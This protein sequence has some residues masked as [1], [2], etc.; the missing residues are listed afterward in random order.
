M[1]DGEVSLERRV[2]VAEEAHLTHARTAVQ[3]DQRRIGDVLSADH[4]PL[5]DPAETYVLGLR[6]AVRE[7]VAIWPRVWICPRRGM[8]IASV[9]ASPHLRKNGW[10]AAGSGDGPGAAFRISGTPRGGLT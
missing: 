8:C 5:I 9:L 10:G 6:D 4:H 3:N 2:E 7:D 1:D